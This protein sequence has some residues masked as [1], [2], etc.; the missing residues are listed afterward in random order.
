MDLRCIIK[1]A[2]TVIK[3]ENKIHKRQ[4]LTGLSAKLKT[5]SRKGTPNKTPT[6]EKP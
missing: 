6:Q 4:D 5:C 2:D 1:V 3:S